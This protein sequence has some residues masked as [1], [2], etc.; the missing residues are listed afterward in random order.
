MRQYVHSRDNLFF[1]SPELWLTRD[2]RV[3]TRSWFIRRLQRACGFEFTGHSMRAGGATTLA[4]LGTAPHVIQ[5][6][7][8]WSSDE[9]QKYVRNHAFLQQ[10]SLHG[11]PPAAQ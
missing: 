8:R 4:L 3:P 7:G 1:L 11:H 2:G 6:I 10:A 9:W 5:A